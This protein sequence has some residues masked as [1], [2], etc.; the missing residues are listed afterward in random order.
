MTRRSSTRAQA[1]EF[2]GQMVEDEGRG[3]LSKVP[4]TLALSRRSRMFPTSALL[5]AELG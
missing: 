3:S 2:Y 4:L 5:R 1:Q